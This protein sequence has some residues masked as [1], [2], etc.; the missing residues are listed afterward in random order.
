MRVI[1]AARIVS[2]G[3]VVLIWVVQ[4]VIYPAFREIA[5]DRFIAWHARYTK[6]ITWVVG[7][8]M[9]AQA[10]A[11]ALLMRTE[12]RSAVGLAGLCVLLAWLATA[13]IAVPIHNRLATGFNVIQINRLVRTNWVRTAAWTIAFAAIAG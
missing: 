12:F 9:F 11:I 3:L 6:T 2:F 13:F 8:L 10:L 1:E 7:P 5:E 4:L